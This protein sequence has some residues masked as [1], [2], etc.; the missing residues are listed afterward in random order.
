M[1]EISRENPSPQE[2]VG[3]VI[4]KVRNAVT[5]PDGSKPVP[6]GSG[7]IT[8]L[9]GSGG[10][11][12][13]YEIWNSQ[14]EVS[15]A[16]KLLHPNYTDDTK[17]RFQTEIKI[18]AKLHHPNIIEIHGV[19]EWNGLPFIEMER[20]DGLTLDRLI[21]DRG[22]L[23]TP[24]AVA[25][26]I[27]VC[28]SLSYA[29]NQEYMIYGTTYHGVIHRDLKP[30]NIMVSHE[31]AVKLMDFGI[32][33]PTDASIHTTDG[34]ILGTMQYLSPEQL[35]G[36]EIDIKTDIYSLG[37]VLYEMITGVKVFPEINMSKLMLSKIKNNYRAIDTYALRLPLR[38]KRVIHKCLAHDPARRVQSAAELVGE[39]ERVYHKLTSQAPKQVIRNYLAEQR[40]QKK[41]VA[42]RTRFPVLP[43]IFFGVAVTITGLMQP[44]LLKAFNAIQQQVVRAFAPPPVA[45]VQPAVPPVPVLPVVEAVVD[46]AKPVAVT[47]HN[48]LAASREPRPS[49]LTKTPPLPTAR[50]ISKALLAKAPKPDDPATA[51]LVL[52]QPEAPAGSIIDRLKSQHQTS[53]L[54]AIMALEVNAGRFAN[55]Q[56]VF[57]VMSI[58]TGKTKKAQL[59][60]MRTLQAVSRGNYAAFLTRGEIDDGEFL[61]N[62]ARLALENNQVDEARHQIDA[63]LRAPCE[64]TDG[65]AVRRDL[66]F[67]RAQCASRLYDLQPAPKTKAEALDRWYDIK[68]LLRA[69]QDHEYYK[70]AASEMQRISTA[71]NSAE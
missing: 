35:D 3:T 13:V 54:L 55:A 40:L 53:D 67:L 30:S 6:M 65:A 48:T 18:T 46:S 43:L 52:P 19:G 50:Q 60:Y 7:T 56:K 57:D 32:A 68:D 1:D 61:L 25:I 21:T 49:R 14:L 34:A 24:V 31:G 17:Q 45:I 58:E 69:N 44:L 37:A 2:P 51:M 28:R 11:A 9:L 4:K 42:P 47:D 26:C 16:V 33:R 66:I 27:M 8:S 12:N 22:A 36:K 15:R 5:M 23:P 64:L 63:G 62:K 59:L 39:L 41:I 38:L 10:M 29:H 70:K 71:T 20:I